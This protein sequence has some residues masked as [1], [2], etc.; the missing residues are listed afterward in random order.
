MVYR[1]PAE[2]LTK[3]DVI[4]VNL[5]IALPFPFHERHVRRMQ[6]Y[7]KLVLLV[8]IEQDFSYRVGRRASKP[9]FRDKLSKKNNLFFLQNNVIVTSRKRPS[10]HATQKLKRHFKAGIFSLPQVVFRRSVDKI[11][12]RIYPWCS[13]Y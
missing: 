3:A 13:F 1:A 6:I 7:Q 4:H 2:K 10:L 12:L 5:T 8:Q 9:F 11:Y